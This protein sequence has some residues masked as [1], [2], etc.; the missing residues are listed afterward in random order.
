MSLI[1]EQRVTKVKNI[2]ELFKTNQAFQNP[3]SQKITQVTSVINQ[4]KSIVNGSTIGSPIYAE[5]TAIL[6]AITQLETTLGRFTSHT[7]NL[8][9]V[10]LSTGLTG[11]NFGTISQVLSTVRKYSNDGGSCELINNAFGA[12]VKFAQIVQAIDNF[13]LQ[14]NELENFPERIAN[15][16]TLIKN[17]LEGQIEQDLQAFAEAQITALQFAIASALESLTG[18]ACISE[19]ISIVG[20]GELR[21]IVRPEV[22]QV[23]N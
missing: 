1:Q 3:F 4:V 22:T 16:I 23:F 21:K 13:I 5:A 12:I 9:G 6:G 14:L 20:S 10:G 11:V 19:I 15:Y 2:V 17:L 18:D 8:S 7:N